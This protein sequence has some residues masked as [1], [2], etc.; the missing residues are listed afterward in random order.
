MAHSRKFDKKVAIDYLRKAGEGGGGHVR[1]PFST[2]PGSN[3]M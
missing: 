2:I 3:S 1:A